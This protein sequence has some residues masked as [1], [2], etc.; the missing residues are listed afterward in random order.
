MVYLHCINFWIDGANLTY[1]LKYLN[2]S[3]FNVIAITG[4]EVRI[5]EQ[6]HNTVQYTF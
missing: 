5:F 2:A 1:H 3:A 6:E 4:M